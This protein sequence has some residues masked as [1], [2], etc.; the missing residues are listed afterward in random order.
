MRLVTYEA[1]AAW[2]AGIMLDEVA[3]ELIER[4]PRG[5]RLTPRR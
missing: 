1:D 3:V 4:L 5:I 2:R